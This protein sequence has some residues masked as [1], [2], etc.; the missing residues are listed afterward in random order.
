MTVWGYARVSTDRQDYT[1]QIEQLKA[2]GADRIVSETASGAI[3]IRRPLVWHR[4]RFASG[5][6]WQ[7]LGRGVGDA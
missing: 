2:A 7:E 3:A 1:A 5:S 6:P 4:S